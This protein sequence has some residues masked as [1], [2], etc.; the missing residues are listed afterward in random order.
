MQS[1]TQDDAYNLRKI[2]EEM[3]LELVRNL[4]RNLKR[5]EKEEEK[6][7]FR[8]E[9]WQ[10][11]KLRNLQRYQKENRAIVGAISPKVEQAVNKALQS[12][13]QKGQNLFQRI[14]KKIK[15]IFFRRKQVRFPQDISS[16]G[17][18][19]RCGKM[20]SLVSMTKSWKS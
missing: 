14:W 5:H 16:H 12:N 2:T 17:L 3:E 18:D 8:W 11:A 13:Y 6:E 9:M 7:V 20:S 19:R 15:S 10:R 4:R 1:Q